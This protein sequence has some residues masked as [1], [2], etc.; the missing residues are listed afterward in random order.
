MQRARRFEAAPHKR[1]SLGF[2]PHSKGMRMTLSRFFKILIVAEFAK[3][4]EHTKTGCIISRALSAV[5]MALDAQLVT[6]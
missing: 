3:A 5:P 4:A 2:R 1:I 6:V